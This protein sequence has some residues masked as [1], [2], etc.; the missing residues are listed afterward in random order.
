V[1][2]GDTIVAELDANGNP[3]VEYHW[4]LLGP[5]ARHDLTNPSNT[6]YYILDAL[7][8]TRLLLDNT[9]NITDTYVYD[10]WGNLLKGSEF[11]T[12]N[13]FT[14]NGAYGYEWIEFTGL[15]HVG[16]R[17]YDP[18]TA[19]WLQRDP[20]GV[21]GGHPNVYL[22]CGNEPLNRVDPTG[23]D[24]HVYE[25]ASTIL[26]VTTIQFHGSRANQTNC[27]RVVKAI[28]KAWNK[29][30][31]YNGKKMVFQI[32]WEIGGKKRPFYDQVSMVPGGKRSWV[33]GEPFYREAWV[34]LNLGLRSNQQHTST[35]YSDDPD[36]DWVVAHEF[37]HLLGL[38][39]RYNEATGVP[40]KGW[41][42]NIMARRWKPVDQRNIDEFCQRAKKAG[43]W[44]VFER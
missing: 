26:V 21:G 25:F 37:G 35:L 13:P 22:Y 8:H 12:P 43:A 7:G 17:E 44:H 29:R 19:R 10:A 41:E 11:N 31:T 18:R 2:D 40:Y 5:I 38:E 36:Y 6:R 23:L 30:F 42:N 32:H 16:A 4:G 9:G 15:F 33:R 39:D 34:H 20:I 24:T 27:E 1:Y 28:Y 14:W 3:V